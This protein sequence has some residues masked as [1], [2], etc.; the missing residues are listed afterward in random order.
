MKTIIHVGGAKG[1]GKTTILKKLSRYFK[2]RTGEDISLITVSEFLSNLA[3]SQFNKKW[4]DLTET[5]RKTLREVAIQHFTSN[6]S[7]VI[8]LDSHYIDLKDG[9]PIDIMP[10]EFKRLIDI[11]V[12]LEAK[13][14]EIL[15]RRIKDGSKQRELDVSIIR[16]EAEAEREAALRIAKELGKPILFMKNENIEIAC[17]NLYE[18]LAEFTLGLREYKYEDKIRNN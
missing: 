8:I 6:E 3:V 17:H 12:I 13:P 2:K 10:D 18:R 1:V 7:S 14:E 11:H 5:E 16:E 9:K 15:E 4:S